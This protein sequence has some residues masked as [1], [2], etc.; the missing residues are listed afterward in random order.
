ML[1]AHE[2]YAVLCRELILEGS[3]RVENMVCSSDPDDRDGA[4]TYHAPELWQL[5]PGKYFGGMGQGNLV[6]D[7]TDIGGLPKYWVSRKNTHLS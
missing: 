6:Y 4:N 3:S 7:S 2:L 5:E 1:K